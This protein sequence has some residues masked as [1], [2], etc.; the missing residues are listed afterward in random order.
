M[1]DEPELLVPISELHRQREELLGQARPAE[2]AAL[3]G[4][5]L[6]VWL[7]WAGLGLVTV[8]PMAVGAM[9]VRHSDPDLAWGIWAVFAVWLAVAYLTNPL[10]RNGPQR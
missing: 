10:L 3:T 5:R 4:W 8:L 7:L 2:P 1:R 9:F 6:V